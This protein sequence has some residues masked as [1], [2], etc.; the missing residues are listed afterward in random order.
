MRPPKKL[1]V[2]VVI[3]MSIGFIVWLA[4]LQPMTSASQEKTAKRPLLTELPKIKNCTEHIKLIKA[5]LVY[6]GELQA[7]AL[8]V[9]NEAYI[10]VVSISVEQLANRER[11]SVVP[12]GFTPDQPPQIVIPPGERMTIT[13]GYL[14]TKAPIRIGGVMFADGT[15]E[16]CDSSLKS[17]RELKDFHT[18]K[19]GPEK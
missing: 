7:A 5:Q 1:V 9:E 4:L 19:G 3:G 10:G 6:Q 14:S 18:R 17:M 13:L 12:S 16:G 8:E 11:H 15:E 2:C